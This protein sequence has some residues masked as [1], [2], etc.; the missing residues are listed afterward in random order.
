VATTTRVL[1]VDWGTTGLAGTLAYRVVD[2]DGANLIA[3]TTSSVTE[4]PAGSG[5]YAIKVT[6]WNT[7]WGAGRVVWDDGTNYVSAAFDEGVLLAQIAAGEAT[8]TLK[9]VDGKTHEQILK[10]W[11]ALMAGKATVTDNGDGTSTVSYKAQDGTTN[12]LQVTY[13]RATGARANTGSIP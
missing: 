10:A 12:A 6:G 1:S 4:S 3:R 5:Q 8:V 2:V 9:S 7:A 11:V 13:T